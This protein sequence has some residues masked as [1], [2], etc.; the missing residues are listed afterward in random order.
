M[1]RRLAL[2]NADLPAGAYRIAEHELDQALAFFQR[3]TVEELE[4]FDKVP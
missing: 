2:R 4:L 3:P 1:L